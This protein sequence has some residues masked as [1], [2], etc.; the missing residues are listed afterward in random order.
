MDIEFLREKADIFKK[1]RQFFD[2]RG[3][4]ETV[5]PVLSPNLIPETC[6]E[7][8]ETAYIPPKGSRIREKQSFYLVPSPEIW[9]KKF[10]SAHKIDIY[11]L[12]PCFRNVE[13]TGRLHSPE[14]TMLE[15]YTMGADY[16]DSIAITEDL[17]VFLLDGTT[18]KSLCPPFEQISIDEAFS[19]FAGFSLYAAAEKNM[20][21]SE[22]RGLGLDPPKGIDAATLFDLIF[23]H[24]VEPNLP[25]DKP[26][27]LK[28]YPSFVPCLARKRPDGKSVE[29]WE[30]YVR[31]IEL[32]NCY[33][34]ETDPTNIRAYFEHEAAAK[35][36][37]SLVPHEIDENFWQIFNDFPR[38]SG[39]AM[40][41]D[42]LIMSLTGKTSIDSVLP[43]PIGRQ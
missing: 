31:G 35:R 12:C 16:E 43:F 30:L 42:R 15:F 27:V 41:V 26:V 40:G 34:E 22:A 9:M 6:L 20:L 13:S 17:F 25:R 7:V 2:E 21:E 10:I 29:R 4:L 33:S 39:V 23:I 3:Y 32:A 14:F 5:T 8:F 1:I 19:H 37:S 28:D 38:C 36:K 18:R 24:A 11:Q